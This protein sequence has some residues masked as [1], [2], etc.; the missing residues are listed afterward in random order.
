MLQI[1]FLQ[2]GSEQKAFDFFME[3]GEFFSGFQFQMA[4]LASNLFGMFGF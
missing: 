2:L 3:I 4:D 1:I